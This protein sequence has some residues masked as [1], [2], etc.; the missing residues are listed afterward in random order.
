MS[1]T[2]IFISILCGYMKSVPTNKIP[3]DNFTYV[4]M[5][6][7]SLLGEHSYLKGLSF[8]MKTL[9]MPSSSLIKAISLICLYYLLFFLPLILLVHL[10][11]LLS[12]RRSLFWNDRTLWLLV[13][14][15]PCSGNARACYS[16]LTAS[17]YPPIK[18]SHY[19]FVLLS[20][21]L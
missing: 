14:I 6:P 21:C 18:I 20:Q 3:C 9:E 17:W 16:R 19:S 5:P 10:L 4:H 7:C 8:M 13:I 1:F 2:L 15:L 11:P 12:I